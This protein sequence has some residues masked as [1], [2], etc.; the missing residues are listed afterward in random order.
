MQ[1]RA[2]LGGGLRRG[3]PRCRLH[4]WRKS[5]S[6][7]CGPCYQG[8][9]ALHVLERDTRLVRLVG[10]VS[11]ENIDPAGRAN[12][13]HGLSS[14]AQQ[15]VRGRTRIRNESLLLFGSVSESCCPKAS[16]KASN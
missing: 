14:L 13:T 8:A 3:T 6:G 7:R 1:P 9:H 16:G 4:L 12:V 5:P 15:A 2:V 10:H 11:D